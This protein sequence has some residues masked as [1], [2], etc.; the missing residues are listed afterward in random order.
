MDKNFRTVFISG[1]SKEDL[2]TVTSLIK[3][4]G[5]E[6]GNL[7]MTQSG[8]PS[9]PQWILDFVIDPKDLEDFTEAV[10]NSCIPLGLKYSS[11]EGSRYFY[12]GG[13]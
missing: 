1:P 8:S 10:R 6:R 9:S 5:W 4:K 7:S 13:N 2:T 3:D 11:M 12:L